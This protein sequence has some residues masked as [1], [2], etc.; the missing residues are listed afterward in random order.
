M[1][2]CGKIAAPLEELFKQSDKQESSIR[3]IDGSDLT[4][5]P[6]KYNAWQ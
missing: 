4:A 2:N 6:E 1:T 5:W 3:E